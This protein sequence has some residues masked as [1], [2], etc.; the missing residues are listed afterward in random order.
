MKEWTEAH[1]SMILEVLLIQSSFHKLHPF[2]L[3]SC[4]LLCTYEYLLGSVK[5]S[6]SGLY[7]TEGGFALWLSEEIWQDYFESKCVD[8]YEMIQFCI[9][10]EITYIWVSVFD[11][12]STREEKGARR[13]SIRRDEAGAGQRVTALKLWASWLL[14]RE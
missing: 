3:S 4:I 10:L 1:F 9:H 11:V 7:S 12:Q 5:F 13:L 14:S 6:V 2:K 8:F